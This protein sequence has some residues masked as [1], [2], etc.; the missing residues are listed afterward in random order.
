MNKIIWQPYTPGDFDHLNATDE[1]RELK[2]RI[3][4]PAYTGMCGDK[5]VAA[6][7]IVPYWRG[8]GEAWVIVCKDVR[9]YIGLPGA[10]RELLDCLQETHKFWRV[11]APVK[12]DN[13]VTRRLVR[14]LGFQE[15]GILRGYA[16]DGTDCYM[17]ARVVRC[18]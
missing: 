8:T 18:Q 16:P 5:I 10:I 17:Y 9:K 13:P 11:Q 2:N 3:S 14:W 1:E 12:V 15:E 4:P 6:A 7:G